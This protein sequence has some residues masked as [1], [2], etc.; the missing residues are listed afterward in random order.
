MKLVFRP[1]LFAA[2]AAAL[3]AGLMAAWPAAAA[4]S[5]AQ[6]RAIAKQAYTY[7]Y[8]MVD[9]YRVQYSYFV[10]TKNPEF[11]APYNTLFNIPRV[12][13]PDDKAIQTPNSDT[14]YSWIGLD[15]RTEPIVFTVPPIEK[16]RYWSLQLIDLYTH[17]FD[18]LGT[19]AT[20]NGGGSFM[21]AGPDWK[22]DKPKGIVKVIRSE[23][24]IASA[25]FR[26]QLF[27]PGD[28]DNVKKVQSQY[29]V[30]PL[31]AFLGGPAPK[32]A[33]S[34]DFIKPLSSDAQK[35]SVDFFRQLNFLLR[36]APTHPSEAA[37]RAQFAKIGVGPGMNFDAR[38]LSPEMKRALEA[39][40][41]DAWSEFDAVKKRV[42]RGEV[43]SGDI[44]G[45]RAHLKNNY[46]YRMTAAVL[47]IYGNSKEEAMYPAYFTDSAGQKLNGSSRYM[48]RFAP[49]QLP[50]VDAFW[51]MTMYE[52][53]AS[54]LVANPLNRYLLNSS[55]L[56]QFKRDADDGL[57][58]VVQNA[59]P[60]KELEAN[61]LPAPSGPF[62]VLL[63]LYVPKPEALSGQ[64]KPPPFKRVE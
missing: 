52:Q 29:I 18:Y 49:G 63:R 44:L 38:Q 4:T 14:P 35:T 5:P 45:T 54:L 20:G 13:T 51:S 41:A 28:L 2:C 60:G 31:S 9:N 24:S 42:D 25:Q 55:M 26:T 16:G 15:L 59:S 27:N 17:N 58:L 32:A 30:K 33:P 7:G 11:K 3:C 48:L 43:L 40:M 36:Y 53:P 10:D 12:F 57:T 46:L 34:I 47:G 62:S 50:P 19:R 56:S 61:W 8:P 23:T 37:L 21:I 6:A 1:G 39:G 22:G 64:W